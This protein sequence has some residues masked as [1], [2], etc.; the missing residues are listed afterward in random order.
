M[1]L[2][3]KNYIFCV[4][5]KVILLSRH[6]FVSLSMARYFFIR[7][8]TLS[9]ARNSLHN[10]PISLLA[11]LNWTQKL[12][13]H[14]YNNFVLFIYYVIILCLLILQSKQKID[15]RTN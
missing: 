4:Y 3:K 11:N 6:I 8:F 5:Y 1:F 2:W 7:P 9:V 12:R 13:I 14:I 15:T 10:P